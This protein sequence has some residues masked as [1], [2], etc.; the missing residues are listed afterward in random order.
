MVKRFQ[1]ILVCFLAAVLFIS[2]FT[3][4]AATNTINISVTYRDI[5]LY[6]DGELITPKDANNNVVEPFIYNGTTYLPI[7]AIGE[8]L[9]KDVEWEG[10]TNSV[11]IGAKAFNTNELSFNRIVYIISPEEEQGVGLEETKTA[12]LK[13]ILQKYTWTQANDID[14]IGFQ[15][16]FYCLVNDDATEA[17]INPY[18]DKT[19]IVLK[20]P[21]Y[22]GENPNYVAPKEVFEEIGVFFKNVFEPAENF[23]YF[24]EDNRAIITKYTGK[25]EVVYIPDNLDGA[26]VTWIGDEAFKSNITVKRVVIPDSVNRIGAFT[27]ANCTSLISMTLPDSITVIGEGAFKDCTS[28]E[29]INI[30]EGTDSLAILG[31]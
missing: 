21:K 20:N 14:P 5:K 29:S 6:V 24:I 9:G 31:N 28:L 25:S 8:A 12:E 22:A 26:Q 18:N 17:Y 4:L 27:F 23:E 15:S 10:S 13:K 3:V 11:F 7:R 19:L 30:P 1:V 2:A 16:N